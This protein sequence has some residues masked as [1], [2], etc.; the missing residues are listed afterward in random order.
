MAAKRPGGLLEIFAMGLR[1]LN[2][3]ETDS[4]DFRS[5]KEA[6]RVC[7]LAGEPTSW[8]TSIHSDAENATGL[9]S[10]AAQVVNAAER[11]DCP[12]LYPTG[13]ADFCAS[14]VRDPFA[15]FRFFR[16]PETRLKRKKHRGFVMAGGLG[17][18]PRLTESESAVLPLNYPP[19]KYLKI[20]CF[21]VGFAN[22][23][24]TN[25]S[26]ANRGLI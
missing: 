13:C 2:D 1:P 19:T 23:G 15:D 24:K 11:G 7:L 6:R 8:G 16:A 4:Q 10:L 5:A 18:E 9:P 25:R 3:Q 12:K 22:A 14:D 17:F 20:L 21:L 26:F